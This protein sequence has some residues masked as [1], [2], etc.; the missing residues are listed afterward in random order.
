M[1]ITQLKIFVI[2]PF[3]KSW[4]FYSL[5]ALGGII[6]LYLLDRERMQRKAALQKMRSDIA[7]NLHKE[8]NMALN[9]INILSEMARIKTDID[10]EKSKE[11]I[12]QIHSKSNDMILAMEDMLW[13]LSPDNDSMQKTVERM[14]EYIDELKNSHGVNI[15]MTVDKKVRSLEL[16]MKLRHEAFLVFKEGIRNLVQAGTKQCEIQIGLSKNNLLFIM[17]FHTA[18]CDMHQLQD[19]LNRRDLEKHLQLINASVDVEVHKTKSILVL[20]IPVN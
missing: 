3:W 4:W 19:L 11:Y 12:A 5:L 18:S 7:G 16:N 8:V 10:P 15:E 9:N 1:N 17:Q 2:T 6:F 20:H 13:S 14:K